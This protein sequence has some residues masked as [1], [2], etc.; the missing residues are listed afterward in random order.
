MLLCE[1]VIISSCDKSYDIHVSQGSDF[2][3][4]VV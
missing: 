3:K 4:A 1:R 2:E